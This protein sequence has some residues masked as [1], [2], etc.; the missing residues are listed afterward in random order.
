[1]SYTANCETRNTK[2]Y[3]TF[4]RLVLR[5]AE[6]GEETAIHLE[7][8]GDCDDDLKGKHFRFRPRE[9]DPMSEV[10]DPEKYRGFQFRQ[11]G[12]TGNMSA[13]EWVRT[14]D[15]PMEEFLQRSRLGEPPPTVWRRRLYLEWYSQNG[16]VVI[17]MADPI[18]EECVREPK[19]DDDEGEWIP[20]PHLAL[21][22]DLPGIERK[23]VLDMTEADFETG[24][25]EHITIEPTAD[26]D[27]EFDTPPTN[28]QR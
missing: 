7:L 10:Y 20:I 28:L 24:E 4:G 9:G 25:V 14:F 8:T 18:L 21:P 3:S 22:P 27:D 12:P 17:E 26:D 1:M 15:C 16:R 6:E 2:H 19:D 5:A 13:K 23:P 11:I